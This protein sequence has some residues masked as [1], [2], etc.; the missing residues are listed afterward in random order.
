MVQKIQVT[1]PC[2]LFRKGGVVHQTLSGW[3]QNYCLFPLCISYNIKPAG[4]KMQP[5]INWLILGGLYMVCERRNRIRTC[6]SLYVG[7]PCGHVCVFNIYVAQKS[8]CM[9][10]FI[11]KLLLNAG[12]KV[13]GM[14]CVW[15]VPEWIGP[16]NKHDLACGIKEDVRDLHKKVVRYAEGYPHLVWYKFQTIQ[17]E[18]LFKATTVS[19][20]C[21]AFLFFCLCLSCLARSC[22][23]IFIAKK[24]RTY[25]LRVL[26]GPQIQQDHHSRFRHK[27]VESLHSIETMLVR[28]TWYD[29]CHEQYT[30]Y[31][32][33]WRAPVS[34]SFF[35]TEPSQTGRAP[36]NC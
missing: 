35:I 8:T 26:F 30:S 12:I 31:T 32:T 20:F 23:Y 1:I 21:S 6:V 10:C 22:V 34:H 27:F 4:P 2:R 16:R 3:C 19:M 9:L 33:S 28:N 17:F 11:N 29:L 5:L 15:L 14:L 24:S 25:L 18:T 36:N 7:G 13:H